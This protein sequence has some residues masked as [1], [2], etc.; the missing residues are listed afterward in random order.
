MNLTPTEFSALIQ[1]A[2]EARSA[3]WKA[4]ARIYSGTDAEQVAALDAESRTAARFHALLTGELDP[5][6]VIA[7]ITAERAARKAEG[8]PATERLEASAS[9]SEPQDP[10][11]SGGTAEPRDRR[12]AGVS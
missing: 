1:A 9:T 12:T 10:D 3:S 2:T 5:A 11:R 8:M 4:G 7:E 6:S